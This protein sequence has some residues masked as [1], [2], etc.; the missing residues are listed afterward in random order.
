MD[1]VSRRG[2]WSR[3]TTGEKKEK[4]EEEEVKEVENRS[5]RSEGPEAE[6]KRAA[7]GDRR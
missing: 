3:R 1:D 7:D 5:V 4:E 6:R 2:R